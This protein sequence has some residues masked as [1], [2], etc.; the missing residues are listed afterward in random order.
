MN[1]I[2]W[3]FSLFLNLLFPVGGNWMKSQYQ[4]SDGEDFTLVERALDQ[5]VISFHVELFLDDEPLVQVVDR[6]NSHSVYRRTRSMLKKNDANEVDEDQVVYSRNSDDT[7]RVIVVLEKTEDKLPVFNDKRMFVVLRQ[8]PMVKVMSY[9]ANYAYARLATN[10]DAICNMTY[11]EEKVCFEW[12]TWDGNRFSEVAP[13]KYI[14]WPD[15]SRTFFSTCRPQLSQYR[16]KNGKRNA[17]INVAVFSSD[18]GNQLLTETLNFVTPPNFGVVVGVDDKDST[19]DLLWDLDNWNVEGNYV[20]ELILNSSVIVDPSSSSLSKQEGKLNGLN[21]HITPDASLLSLMQLTEDN[22]LARH[23]R[24]NVTHNES[25]Y[26]KLAN[27]IHKHAYLVTKIHET[28]VQIRG[29]LFLHGEKDFVTLRKN[30]EEMKV[31]KSKPDF[32]DILEHLEALESELELIDKQDSELEERLQNMDDNVFN[33]SISLS[34]IFLKP[35]WKYQEFAQHQKVPENESWKDSLLFYGFGTCAYEQP[36][37]N[38]ELSVWKEVTNEEIEIIADFYLTL[39]RVHCTPEAKQYLMYLIDKEFLKLKANFFDV[40]EDLQ[41]L[42]KPKLTLNELRMLSAAL[43]FSVFTKTYQN[44][45]QMEAIPKR[46]QTIDIPLIYIPHASRTLDF[47]LHYTAL[48]VKHARGLVDTHFIKMCRNLVITL[49]GIM[50]RLIQDRAILE[51]HCQK[52]LSKDICEIESKVND[53]NRLAVN[54]ALQWVLHG[55][56]PIE[57][58]KN[59]KTEKNLQSFYKSNM[60]SIELSLKYYE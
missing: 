4:L 6:N 5:I 48:F 17:N 3:K 36:V 45:I 11:L 33:V 28:R 51:I 25:M 43:E 19:Y 26:E 32:K 20:R 38:V 42:Q 49:K 47:M 23:E 27:N 58:N 8:D 7:N 35:G 21:A 53:G 2:A 30:P 44:L 56:A 40:P 37:W 22:Y 29:L 46:Q 52:G 1:T 59:V 9:F 60:N 15:C 12:D 34:D 39:L 55:L 16:L 50:T 18:D 10:S 24:K 13:Y 31:L 41:V 57:L 14:G 54:A